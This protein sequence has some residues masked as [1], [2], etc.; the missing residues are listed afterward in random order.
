M[1]LKFKVY[2]LVKTVPYG[3]VTT[4]KEIAKALNVKCYRVIGQ[5]LKQ[6]KDLINIP[7]YK[8]VHANGNVGGYVLGKKEKVKLLKKDN[9]EVVGDKIVNFEKVLF[10]FVK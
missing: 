8:V 4:Y 5:A 6:N 7:C 9:I 2:E 3:K 1:L 10:K